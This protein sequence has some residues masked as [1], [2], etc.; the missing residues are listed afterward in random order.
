MSIAPQH[1]DKLVEASRNLGVRLA[2]SA[3]RARRRDAVLLMAFALLYVAL[4]VL[5][6]SPV[7]GTIIDA[8]TR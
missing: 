7:I 4:A 2:E 1:R 5:I 6:V 3:N 8:V